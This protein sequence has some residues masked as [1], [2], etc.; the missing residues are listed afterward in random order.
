MFDILVN[1][2]IFKFGGFIILAFVIS[3]PISWILSKISKKLIFALPIL[4]ALLGILFLVMALLADSWGPVI[5]FIMGIFI[6]LAFVGAMASS[7]LLNIRDKDKK[8]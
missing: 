3:L 7:V 6:L 8:K 2:D 4:L 1:A 5:F